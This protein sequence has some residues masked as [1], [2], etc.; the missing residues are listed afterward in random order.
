VTASGSD[1]ATATAIETG[2]GASGGILNGARPEA[3]AL[4]TLQLVLGYVLASGVKSLIIPQTLGELVVLGLMWVLL[5]GGGASLLHAGFA[6]GSHGG[7][8]RSR[9]AAYIGLM[10]MLIG[11]L[12][13]LRF[14]QPVPLLFTVAVVAAIALGAPPMYLRRRPTAAWLLQS[15]TIGFLAPYAAW[16]AAGRPVTTFAQWTFAGLAFLI[17]ALIPLGQLPETARLRARGERPIARS[18]GVD[19]VVLSSSILV[20]VGLLVLLRALVL[21]YPSRLAYAAFA[22]A[23]VGWTFTL[24]PWISSGAGFTFDQQQAGYRTA[25]ASYLA[26]GVALVYA[27]SM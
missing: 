2:Q 6:E 22:A 14:Q 18:L 21:S 1:E 27:L 8:A 11:Q 15:L 20:V 26:T 19:G 17:A 5:L 12:A 7:G 10:V 23:A 3:W 4:T 9:S 25:I 16:A 24:A 13:S